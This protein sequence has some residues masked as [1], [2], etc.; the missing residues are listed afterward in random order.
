MIHELHIIFILYAVRNTQF[1]VL[2][3]LKN[4]VNLKPCGFCFHFIGSSRL[5]QLE[6][7][8]LEYVEL[9]GWADNVDGTPNAYCLKLALKYILNYDISPKRI[10]RLYNILTNGGMSYFAVYNNLDY[11]KAFV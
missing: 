10:L 4:E 3:C 11:I 2:K 9:D 5:K 1:L 8:C 6:T 7:M